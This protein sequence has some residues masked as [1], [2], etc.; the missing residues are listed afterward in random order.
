MPSALKARNGRPSVAEMREQLSQLRK[1]SSRQLEG[2]FRRYKDMCQSSVPRKTEIVVNEPVNW[3]ALIMSLPPPQNIE[4]LGCGVR[5]VYLK[6]TDCVY[7]GMFRFHV[8]RRD[9]TQVSFD[10]RDAFDDAYHNYKDKSFKDDVETAFR[11]AVLHQ[12]IEFKEMLAKDSQMELSSHISGVALTWER[13][14]VQHFPITFQDLLDAFLNEVQFNLEQIKVEYDEQH[15]YRIKDPAL[16]Q[17]W[18]TYHRER[19]NYRVISTEEAMEQD[20]L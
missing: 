10:W 13:A 4:V 17:A 6:E 3:K 16:L 18:Q 15:A 11:G 9:G 12:L 1:P 8:E 19:A 7:E 20:H 2:I 14:V 5:K